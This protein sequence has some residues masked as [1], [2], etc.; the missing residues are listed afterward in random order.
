MPRGQYQ[1]P[2]KA[3][4][5]DARAPADTITLSIKLAS[6]RFEMSL[7]H[8][9]FGETTEADFRASIDAWLAL[10]FQALRSGVSE[11]RANLKE[12]TP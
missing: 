1:R 12:P 7:Q 9:I 10:S 3:P 6:G 8:P 5:P 2:F 11:M 4:D